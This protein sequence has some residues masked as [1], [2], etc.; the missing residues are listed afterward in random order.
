[1]SVFSPLPRARLE[2]TPLEGR[3]LCSAQLVPDTQAFPYRAVAKVIAWWDL[4]HNGIKDDGELY[5]ATATLIAHHSALTAGHVVYDPAL[6]GFATGIFIIPGLNGGPAPLGIDAA[7]SWVIPSTFK[8]HPYAGDDVAVLNFA[9]DIGR[10]T[11]FFGLAEPPTH[12]LRHATLTNIGYPGDTHSGNQQFQSR[13][14]TRSLTPTEIQY[15]TEQLQVEHGS[16]GSPMFLLNRK[17][18]QPQIV[19]VHSRRIDNGAIGISARVTPLVAHFIQTAE[20]E[21]GP[22]GFVVAPGATRH[23]STA[24]LVAVHRELADLP[25]TPV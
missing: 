1:M 18:H 7:R 10:T 22:G 5:G 16:S 9:Q 8:R 17:T 13:G 14:Q 24:A 11:G 20:T 21:H 6:G 3:L 15:R 25:V 12:A 4:N 23:L 2:V 19:G